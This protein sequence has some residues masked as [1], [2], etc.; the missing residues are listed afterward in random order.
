M[1]KRLIPNSALHLAKLFVTLVAICLSPSLSAQDK[2][3]LSMCVFDIAGRDGIVVKEMQMFQLEAFRWNVE[4]SFQV[5]QDDLAASESFK[6]GHCDI[7]NLPGF[8]VREFNS[9]TGS[10]NAIGALPSYQHLGVVIKSLSSPKAAKLMRAGDYEVIGIGPIGSLFLFVN[11]RRLQS[12][13]DFAA[14]RVA[15][16][17][18]A[19]ESSYMAERLKLKTVSS[20]LVDSMQKF[21]DN[22]VDITTAPSVA[23]QS[24]KLDKGLGVNGGIIKWPSAHSTMQLIVRWEQVPE[25]FTQRSRSYWA[26]RYPAL[27]KTILAKE[28]AIPEGYWIDL[29]E[30]QQARWNALFR[31]SRISLRNRKVY[32]AKALTLFRKVRCKLEPSRT[33]CSAEDRE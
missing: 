17:N 19:P 31:A 2:L 5:Y 22:T 14:K 12:P 8:R 11:D 16:V 23:Y 10:L 26:N 1:L 27:V 15:V 33:E 3:A 21:S 9:F 7:L 28:R 24:R 13:E 30:A 18:T 20:S 32:N 4:L 29:K 6:N 25:H